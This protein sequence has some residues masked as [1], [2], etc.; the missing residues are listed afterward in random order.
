[1]ELAKTYYTQEQIIQGL[2]M[3]DKLA[4]EVLYNNYSG[5]L[6]GII[7]AVFES[8]EARI[9]VLQKA[10]LKVWIDSD[11]FDSEKEKFFIW[12]LKV[13]RDCIMEEI[14][15]SNTDS[16]PIYGDGQLSD[17]INPCDY[18]VFYKVF[19]FGTPTHEVAEELSLTSSDVH[20]CL[21]RA[22]QNLKVHFAQ[23]TDQ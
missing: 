12:I 2:I 20:K 18:S 11:H 4:L 6:Y 7:A 10:I 9:S 13:V 5:K 3:K 15:L 8:H 16:Q 19:F 1:M 17:I 21:Y 22:M 14:R 23:S